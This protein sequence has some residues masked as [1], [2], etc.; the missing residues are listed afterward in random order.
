MKEKMDGEERVIA[1][2]EQIVRRLGTTSDMTHDMLSI[3]ST[4]DHRFSNIT[5]RLDPH[6]DHRLHAAEKLLLRSDLATSTARSHH[7]H[8]HHMIWDGPPDQAQAYLDA[9]DEVHYLITTLH[10]SKGNNTNTL[11]RAQAA[12]DVAMAR[13]A[14]ELRHAL[15]HHNEPLEPEQF[16]HIVAR[17]VASSRSPLAEDEEAEEELR[18]AEPQA[19]PERHPK[20]Q[21]ECKSF[22][23]PKEPAS[24]IYVFCTTVIPD[25]R[26][27]VKRLIAGDR[28]QECCQVYAAAR[29]A[30]LDDNLSRLGIER[31]GVDDVQ[32]TAW[33]ILEDKI[34]KWI[35]AVRVAVRVLFVREK[36]LADR[37]FV[38]NGNSESCFLDSCRAP[39]M[40]LLGF[41]EAVA[42]SR[43]SPEKLFRILDIYETLSDLV[44]D[45]D[46]IFS[47]EGIRAEVSGILVRLGEAASCTFTEL[48][49]AIRRES[50]K[51]PIPGGAVHPLT[52]YVMNYIRFLFDYTDTLKLLIVSKPYEYTNPSLCHS[53][54]PSP[55]LSPLGL[56]PGQYLYED[57]TTDLALAPLALQLFNVIE[58]LKNN[59]EGKSRLY[60]D[61]ALTYLFLMNNIHYIVQKVKGS[62]LITYLGDD[63][64]RRHS[65]KV[66]QY[67]TNY[68]R[69]SWNKVVSCLRDEG[70]QS[71]AGNYSNSV[72]SKGA[73]KE[74]FKRFNTVFEE[75]LKTQT[76]W[77]V[78]DP[79]LREEL[80]ISVTEKLLPAYRSFMGR[81]GIH[82]EGDKH[83]ERYLKYSPEDLEECLLGLFQ[84]LPAP[85][86][87]HSQKPKSLP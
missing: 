55:P 39:M 41:S 62:E 10:V 20:P 28:E 83:A 21:A 81:I 31:L 85:A 19:Q 77:I 13:L 17:T 43:R 46:F 82:L 12:H 24:L 58:L 9:V 37:I 33:E 45:I 57:E 79:Q 38:E 49:N 68:Q 48:S 65:G 44:P 42:I 7:H 36:E 70:V 27:I 3:L 30:V 87:A 54:G 73:L 64:V 15:H 52:R 25:I 56:G 72:V 69:V 51:R 8:Y 29:R 11:E 2:A 75:V 16:Q 35:P 18:Q 60:K 67:A 76:T 80:R 34:K 61:S 78:A 1:T 47:D 50:S 5:D 63:W 32:K 71:V 74:R 6:L 53:P 22:K 23:N 40:R 86:S 4:F 66:R 26:A 59:L 84:E 14:E